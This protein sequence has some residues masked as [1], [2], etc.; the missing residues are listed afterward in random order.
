MTYK[1]I[2]AIGLMVLMA[3][4][5]SP[6]K[7]I[8]RSTYSITMEA[9]K[10]QR[11]EGLKAPNGWLSLA[12]LF[13]L[14]SGEQTF[15]SANGCKLKFPDTAP[16]LMGHFTLR[17]DSV[18][19]APAPGISLIV[20]EKPFTETLLLWP[21]TTGSMPTLHY[22]TFDWTLIKRGDLIGVRLWDRAHPA[23]AQFTGIEYFPLNE[24]WIIPA[25]FTPAQAGKTILL[26][27]VLGMKIDQAV[28]GTLVFSIKGKTYRIEALDGGED[29]LFLIFSDKTT[30]GSTY[31]GGRYLYVPRPDARGQVLIDFNKATNPPCA[32]TTF[33]TCLLPPPQHFIEVDIEAGEKNWGHH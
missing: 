30:G 27:N 31:G 11:I 26:D 25:Q 21:T 5:C 16:Q 1:A 9:W 23:I 18:W 29:E 14:K 19:I 17:N 6:T 28:E 24:K 20:G 10:K 7:K 8:D 33:A 15:G 22:Q 13:W 12:G 2:L 4:A 32:F 3:I